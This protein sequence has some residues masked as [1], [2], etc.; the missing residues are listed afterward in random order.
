MLHFDSDY[1]S[2]AAPEILTRLT[3]MNFEQN[4]GYGADHYCEDAAEKIRAACGA[5]DAAVK[6]LVGGTQTNAVI[7]DILMERYQGVVAVSTGHINGHEAGAVEFTGHKVLTLPGKDGKLNAGVLERYLADFYADEAN[8]HLVQ[9]GLV[10]ISQPTEYG[11][12]YTKA[13]LSAL[14]VICDRYQLKFYL[15]GARL[16]YGLG[17]KNADFT[18]K[19]IAAVCDG[20][21]I[22]GTK[23]GALFGEAVV[24]PNPRLAPCFL[25]QIKQHCAL[26]AKGWLLGVQFDTLFSDEL[27][28]RL[29]RHG[30]AMAE[31]LKT[32]LAAKGL[33]F[34]LD[35]PTNQL[36][37][38]ME[39]GR[40]A[41]LRQYATFEI[42]EKYDESH[43]VVRFVTSW[44]TREEEVQAL[45]A[46]I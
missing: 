17:A 7:L 27:Y 32:G 37:L 12:V 35:S 42:W 25:T 31:Q 21:Y 4:S 19:D 20:F 26:L 3:E 10:Y 8:D 29:G 1:M 5:P 9:P 41:E 30:V 13:E 2:G 46:L 43:T 22:G 40:M 23:V 14:R 6:F 45:L 33:P 44:A 11:T 38:I 18:L 16:G 34:F 36:F 39:N 28:F 24:I 15:D